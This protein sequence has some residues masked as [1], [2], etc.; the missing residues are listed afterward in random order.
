MK[1]ILLLIFCGLSFICCSKESVE[2]IEKFEGKYSGTCEHISSNGGG[3][4]NITVRVKISSNQIKINSI[5]GFSLPT[6]YYNITDSGEYGVSGY[7]QNNS[8]GYS[9]VDI[10]GQSLSLEYY[11]P[12]GG[13]RYRLDLDKD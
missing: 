10:R 13:D 1:K 7:F 2:G 12:K 3:H 11:P 9:Y 8:D 4:Y 6:L 5:S